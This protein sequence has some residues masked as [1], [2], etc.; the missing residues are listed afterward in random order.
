M[1]HASD[2]VIQWAVVA[3]PTFM[4]HAQMK[5]FRFDFKRVFSCIQNGI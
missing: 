4:A 2:A 5:N 3:Y 1:E